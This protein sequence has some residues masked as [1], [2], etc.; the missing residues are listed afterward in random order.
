VIGVGL[1]R[2]GVAQVEV[3]VVGL[4]VAAQSGARVGGG[5]DLAQLADA[6]P[7]V[8]LVL[9]RLST[10]QLAGCFVIVA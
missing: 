7:G 4:A 5:V 1:G 8:D 6:D 9:P 2:F 3:L 10:G